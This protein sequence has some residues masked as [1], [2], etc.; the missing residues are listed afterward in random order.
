MFL[1]HRAH[2]VPTGAYN[3]YRD[4]LLGH[5]DGSMQCPWCRTSPGWQAQVGCGAT[6]I[7]GQ[8]DTLEQSFSQ[9]GSQQGATTTNCSQ[10]EHFSETIV[11]N[12]KR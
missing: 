1:V 9:V 11:G 5:A 12:G 7:I 10:A 8:E 4:T 6:S 3:R 2:T